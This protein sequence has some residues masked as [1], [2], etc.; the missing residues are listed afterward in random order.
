MILISIAIVVV[1]DVVER[2]IA[3]RDHSLVLLVL[4]DE[5]VQ[6]VCPSLP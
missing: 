6:F 1:R 2:K 4:V 5:V 3:R